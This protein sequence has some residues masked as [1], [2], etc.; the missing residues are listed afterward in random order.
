MEDVPTKTLRD[1]L[2][3]PSLAVLATHRDGQPHASLVGFASTED[4]ARIVF[5]TPRSTRKY[6][7]LQADA[8]VAMLVDNRSHRA[9]DFEEAAAATVVGRAR[10]VTD[11]EAG[12]FM[13]RYLARHP[14]L[15]GFVASAASVL[16]VVDVESYS[17]VTQ[18]QQVIQ[19]TW[20]NGAWQPG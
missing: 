16:I 3:R 13:N 2:E 10:D 7:N 19:F 8:R 12:T 1:L 17:L 9:S 18:F 11:D 5:A 4:L 20:H 14:H 15:E 6:A